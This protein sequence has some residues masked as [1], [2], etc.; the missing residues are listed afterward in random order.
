VSLNDTVASA[1]AVLAAPTKAPWT[2]FGVRIGTTVTL[3]WADTANNNATYTLQR[4]TNNGATWTNV[5]TTLA[6][7]ATTTTQ[8]IAGTA[9]TTNQYRIQAVNSV[10]TVNSNIVTIVT[11]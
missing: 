5:T 9:A 7:N 4:S 10:S 8:N 2:V 3:N 1:A 6:G 11:P